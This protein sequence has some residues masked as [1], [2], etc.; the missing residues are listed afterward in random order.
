ML[1]N[2]AVAKANSYWASCEFIENKLWEVEIN[3]KLKWI[4]YYQSD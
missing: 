2:I 4:E 3:C 1:D